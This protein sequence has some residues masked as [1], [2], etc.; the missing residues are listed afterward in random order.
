MKNLTRRDAL[1][2]G[3]ASL[4]TATLTPNHVWAQNPPQALPRL[5][6]LPTDIDRIRANAAHPLLAPM[7]QEW[8]SQSIASLAENIAHFRK[9]GE[10]IRDFMR[11][12]RGVEYSALIQ[13]VEPSAEREASLLEALEAFISFEKWDYFVEDGTE[14]LGIQRS[15]I[16][17]TRLLFA[18]EVLGDAVDNDLEKRLLQAIADKGCQACYAT[19]YDMDNPETVKGW[20]FDELH[21]DHYDTTMERW[22]MI[23]GAN[24]LRAAPTGALGLG[25]LA[26]IGRDPRAEKWLARAVSSTQRF[27]DLFSPDGSF[28]EGIS[29][30]QYS[31]RTTLPFIDAH[32]RLVGDVDWTQVVNWDGVL[33][34]IM[35][36]Q[37]GKR[38]NGLPD[39]VN[40]S[41][42]RYS[43]LPGAV[44]RMGAYTGNP[45]AGFAATYAGEPQFHYDYLWF[46]PAAPSR[47][48]RAALKNYR[49]DLNWIITRTGWKAEDTVIA[50]KSGG[51]ANHEHADRH[52][53]TLK[54]YGE[55]LLNDHFGASYDRR[56]PGWVMR[57][58]RAHNAVLIDGKGHPYI[59]GTEGVNDSKAYATVLAYH[60]KGDHIWWTSDA[61]AAYILDNYHAHQV[62]RTVVWA[63]PG[64]I[65]VFDQ[66]RF[67][68]R[69]QTLDARFYPDNADG[70]AAMSIDGPRFTIHRPQAQLHALTAGNTLVGPR[71]AKLEVPL[72]VGDFPCIEVHCAEALTHHLFT[73]MVPTA[74][75]DSAKPAIKL[76]QSKGS[77]HFQ[78]NDQT[79]KISPTT[80]EPKVEFS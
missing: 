3:G 80:H 76:E 58:T 9:T 41:D 65:V 59:D 75:A 17:L 2:L 77:W 24:N 21:A 34:Y 33:E 13:I 43:I 72:E 54:A 63:K 8:K 73:A 14:T 52:H 57:Q 78:Y 68:Y 28:F 7:Y 40:F 62:L 22:P 10:I 37:M 47:P 6:F 45:L 5:F 35:G 69:P 20:S 48:P 11:C 46:E 18:R 12:V 60:D 26:L 70:K 31:M 38:P 23:L 19:I 55:R 49:S 71:A 39:V 66:V 67:R 51:P 36:M 27:L 44:S 29:Y 61:S 16:A 15:S 74:G 53:I 4:A 1:R 64:F 42:S 56:T 30:L 79:I 50:F 32:T 25:A